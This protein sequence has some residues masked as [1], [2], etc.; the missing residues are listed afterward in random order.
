MKTFVRRSLL[1]TAVVSAAL[2]GGGTAAPAAPS[3]CTLREG[4]PV[5]GASV[6]CSSGSGEVRVVIECRLSKPGGDPV[7]ATRNGPWVGVG[8]TSSATCTGAPVRSDAWF[9]VR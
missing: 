9:E 1:V 5:D 4:V 8:A 2:V 3:G 6:R 7:F